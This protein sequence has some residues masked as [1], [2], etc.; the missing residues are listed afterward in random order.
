MIILPAFGAVLSTW[1]LQRE[2][3]RFEKQNKIK[4]KDEES[5]RVRYIVLAALPMLNTLYGLAIAL[6][7]NSYF[8]DAQL[9][10]NVGLPCGVMA[11]ALLLSTLAAMIFV[12]R[13]IGRG[14][15]TEEKAFTRTILSTVALEL[16]L[17]IGLF[18]L[19]G[20]VMGI[21]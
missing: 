16:V 11:G 1:L 20:I 18:F 7:V 10:R 13:S 9:S 14:A 12:K 17:V 5:I 19:T 2:R 21:I 8:S 15:L 4:K 6:I 3:D